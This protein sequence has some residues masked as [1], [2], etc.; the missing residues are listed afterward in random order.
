MLRIKSHLR[1]MLHPG[2]NIDLAEE[3]DMNSDYWSNI[4]RKTMNRRR[5]LMATAGTGAAAAVLAACGGGGSSTPSKSGGSASLISAIEDTS[6]QAKRGG[7]N[8][9]FLAS[10]P[11]TLDVQILQPPLPPIKNH[12][13]ARLVAERPGY[14]TPAEFRDLDPEL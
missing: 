13:Y 14:L 11:S 5:M 2:A 9:W 1:S 7:V 12:I 6:K 10:E 4:S 3:T 8:K